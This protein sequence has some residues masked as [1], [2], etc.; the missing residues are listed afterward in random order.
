[1]N[2]NLWKMQLLECCG[3]QYLRVG[4]L[5]SWLSSGLL[6]TEGEMAKVAAPA[7]CGDCVLKQIYC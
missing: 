3:N 4:S 1:M 7:L 5:G 2:G 6:D